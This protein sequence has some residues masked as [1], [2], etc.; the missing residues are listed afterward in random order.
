MIGMGKR[1]NGPTRGKWVY[2]ISPNGDAEALFN[3]SKL[4]GRDQGPG[5]FM[6]VDPDGAVLFEA[7][8]RLPGTSY[9]AIY[10]IYKATPTHRWRVW[11]KRLG[12]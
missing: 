12:L 8:Q 3:A 4:V 9:K 7:R 11:L 2:R 1:R 5:A 10:R 6:R